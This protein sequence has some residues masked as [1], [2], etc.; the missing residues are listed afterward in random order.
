M[1]DHAD[2][3]IATLRLIAGEAFSV[4]MAM[5]DGVQSIS[6]TRLT[7]PPAAP[8]PAK[9][10]ALFA[11]QSPWNST[12]VNPVLGTDIMPSKNQTP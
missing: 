5:D 8:Q 7:H 12:P 6:A 9:A 11:A 10:E 3:G 4:H 2:I 1:T